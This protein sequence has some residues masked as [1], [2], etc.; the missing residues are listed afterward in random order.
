MNALL[1]VDGLAVRY[2]G[3]PKDAVEGVSFVLEPGRCVAFVGETGSGKTSSV[4][5]SV[6]LLDGAAVRA[7][8]L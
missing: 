2:D 6:G 8:R 5:A 7:D 1:A 4:M 3:Q